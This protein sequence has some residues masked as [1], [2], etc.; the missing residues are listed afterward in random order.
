MSRPFATAP[1]RHCAMP[2]LLFL[3]LAARDCPDC[4]LPSLVLSPLHRC[5]GVRIAQTRVSVPDGSNDPGPYDGPRRPRSGGSNMAKRK[6][7]GSGDGRQPGRGSV[8]RHRAGQGRIRRRRHGTH[9][10][11]GQRVRRRATTAAVRACP[12]SVENTADAVREQGQEALPVAHG[13]GRPALHRPRRGTGARGL[14]PCRRPGQQRH[15]H[16]ARAPKPRC[17]TSSWPI[18]GKR[19]TSTSWRH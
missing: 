3:V 16:R 5:R 19:S 9:R 17:W 4:A 6:K 10:P 14:G 11:R 15:L 18:C 7:S 8:H 2:T 12:G 1:V 13:P